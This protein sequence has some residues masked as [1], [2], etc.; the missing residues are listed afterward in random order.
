MYGLSDQFDGAVQMETTALGGS[1]QS[2]AVFKYNG[3]LY[4]VLQFLGGGETEPIWVF[5]STDAGLTWAILDAANSPQR[6]GNAQSAGVVFDGLHTLTIAYTAVTRTVNIGPVV[7]QTF[8]LSTGLWGAMFGAAGSPNVR[9]VNQIFVRP[10]G[11]T[12]VITNRAFVGGNV[13]GITAKV[14]AGGV[15]TAS[16][17]LDSNL[18]GGVTSNG[19]SA[20]AMDPTG[21]LHVFAFGLDAGNAHF[22]LYQAF[23]SN[24]TLG[25]FTNFAPG[26]FHGVIG[27]MANPIISG[28]NLVYGVRNA[29]GTLPLVLVGTPLAGPVF[30]LSGNIDPAFAGVADPGVDPTLVTDGTLIYAVYQFNDGA[31]TQVRLASTANLA[32][33]LLGWSGASYYSDLLGFFQQAAQ[34]PTI[35]VIG[36][37]PAVTL[38]GF[39]PNPIGQQPTNFFFFDPQPVPM[40]L[41]IDFIGA[42][43]YNKA[44]AGQ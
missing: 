42:K 38:Q 40:D 1:G 6:T 28:A 13:V 15:W 10:D 16:V 17:N 20:V 37:V 24:N 7:L 3:N 34:Y 44:K 9:T 18:P 25:S 23:E 19:A 26:V 22:T 36:G 21:R 35:S 12:V 2:A 5:K 14:F 32:A 43:V 27:A 4:Q 33:P 30:A 11:S 39:A 29:A 31:V 41:I 8:D